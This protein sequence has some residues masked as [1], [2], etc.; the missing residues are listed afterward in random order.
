MGD[1]IRKFLVYRFDSECEAYFNFNQ[2]GYNPIQYYYPK[3]LSPS[4]R[5]LLDGG[6]AIA[7][8]PSHEF[9]GVS[10]HHTRYIH[11]AVPP[12]CPAVPFEAIIG[13]SV[14]PVGRITTQMRSRTT[15]MKTTCESFS[16]HNERGYIIIA[17]YVLYV[18]SQDHGPSHEVEIVGKRKVMLD[19]A[20]VSVRI[21]M[22]LGRERSVDE[23][24][25]GPAALVMGH[26]RPEI[27]GSLMDE[28]LLCYFCS[29]VRSISFYSTTA[30]ISCT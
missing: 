1:R 17:C 26:Y 8:K 7:I 9:A 22:Q 3:S 28:R 29:Q 2:S 14:M 11:K 21:G 18:L 19:F 5:F 15:S 23:K 16:H 4:R 20:S 6:C 24:Q 13:L 27:A 30:F 25:V 12:E 10:T